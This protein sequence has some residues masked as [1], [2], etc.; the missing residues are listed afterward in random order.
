MLRESHGV[1][2]ILSTMM[3]V[4]TGGCLAGEDMAGEPPSGSSPA[5]GPSE[6]DPAGVRPPDRLPL[7]AP[8]VRPPDLPGVVIDGTF[9]A[10]PGRD[11]A[12]GFGP[13]GWTVALTA[14]PDTLWPTQYATLTATAN[15]DVGPTP[16]YIRILNAGSVLAICGSGTTCSTAV[17]RSSIQD[18]Y[19]TANITDSAGT[20]IDSEPFGEN[21]EFVSW[22]GSGITLAV[23]TPTAPLGASVNLTTTTTYDIGPSPFYVEI[24]D[25]TTGTFLT[26]C[27]I[28]TTC[29]TTVSESAATTHA[30]KACF[31]SF[32]TSFPPPNL[33]ECATVKYVTWSSSGST[34]SLT[35]PALFFG[36]A[37]VTAV[38]S[39]DV[40]PTPYYI[41][42]YH[43]ESG[44]IAVCGFGTTCSATFA[45]GVRGPHHLVAFIAS[46][47]T[48][49]PPPL[50]QAGSPV[51]ETFLEVIK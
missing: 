42:I 30:Y 46:A 16:Y 15:M 28:G 20:A 43:L 6:T 4:S 29:S 44:R 51:V 49:L 19:F 1:V 26:A 34:V 13:T 12:I 14:S 25:D 33:L 5:S 35:A 32:G 8:P 37:T 11:Q 47:S 18:T 38:A 17:T 7:K 41:Q 45:P 24:F 36:A 10:K 21:F 9:P 23:S 27:G 22:H 2:V 50:A 3:A 48:V 40:G 31:S 39:F